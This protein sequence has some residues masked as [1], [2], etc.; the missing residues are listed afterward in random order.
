MLKKHLDEARSGAIREMEAILADAGSAINAAVV[1]VD[2]Y[3]RV[4]VKLWVAERDQAAA[5]E[6]TIDER[7]SA[8][9]VQY[10]NKGIEV[11]H[12][13]NPE[14]EDDPLLQLAWREGIARP[15]EERLRVN[16][17]LRHHAGWFRPDAQ[18]SPLWPLEDGPPIIVFHGFKGGAG[19]TTLLAS[20]ALASAR[21]GRTVAVVDMDLDA[22]GIGV[23]LSMDDD[24][25]TSAWGTLDFL[26][27]AHEQH[28]LSD[29]FHVCARPSLT[30]S[31]LLR[32]FPAGRL[33]DDY[34]PKLAR[35][36]LDARSSF[37][38]HPLG[39]LLQAIRGLAPDL[40][41]LDGRAGLSPTAGLLLSGL[42]HLHVLVATSSEQSMQGLE[43]VVRHL[44]YGQALEGRKQGACVV[45]QALVP[46]SVDVSAV[47][48]DE[49]EDRLETMFRE[50]YYAKD[51]DANDSVW[52]LDD[53][54]S[55]VAPHVPVAISYRARLAHFGS[56]E[57]VADLL[58]EDPEYVALHQR[59]DER[60]GVSSDPS[61]SEATD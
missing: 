49:F 38:S 40:I 30:G 42:A 6:R 8:A 57:L 33:T 37:A 19:R 31:G 22:P 13:A 35:V 44:G 41:L 1:V 34:L 32:V 27:E 59:I 56:I 20:Y 14:I 21:R 60:L 46:D 58:A 54:G 28:P 18:A 39:L 50:N 43:R 7:L 10:W 52:S 9:C 45:V 53:L 47:V 55:N 15:G 25:T 5:H 17:R 16:D 26:L 23:M 2:I 3:G 4:S 36:D 61:A 51:S 11:S 48:R 24:G 29:Y 12:R